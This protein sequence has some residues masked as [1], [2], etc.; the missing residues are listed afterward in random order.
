[1]AHASSRRRDPHEVTSAPRARRPR[2]GAA[3]GGTPRIRW[4]RVGRVAILIVFII[5]AGL[6]VGPLSSFWAANG[7]AAT[8][9]A[10]VEQLRKENRELRAAREALRNG[11]A[12]EAEAR[13]LGMV[14]PGE[15][16]FVVE[17]LPRGR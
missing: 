6:Y 8:R 5:V 7:E 4:D 13:R 3:A 11:G 10:Q 1:M 12:L 15:R 14:R 16:P 2:T 17:N 9:R